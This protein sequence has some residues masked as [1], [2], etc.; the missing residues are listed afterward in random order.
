MINGDCR[1]LLIWT[2]IARMPNGQLRPTQTLVPPTMK[3]IVS[4]FGGISGV[5]PPYSNC[6]HRTPL[7]RPLQGQLLA[8]GMTQGIRGWF[9]VSDSKVISGL[10]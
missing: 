8:G 1:F 4:G 10:D 6:Y 9:G 2:S 3:A 7:M 5:I